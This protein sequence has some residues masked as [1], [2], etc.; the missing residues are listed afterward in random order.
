M[1]AGIK[2]LLH[3]I[4]VALL[5]WL[6]IFFSTDPTFMSLSK[7]R[8]CY[9]FFARS[10]G[11]GWVTLGEGENQKKIGTGRYKKGAFLL[12]KRK[13]AR[14]HPLRCCDLRDRQPL[15]RWRLWHTVPY[16][17]KKSRQQAARQ[18]KEWE[19][20]S[21]DHYHDHCSGRAHEQGQRFAEM[22]TP[23]RNILFCS[24][25]AHSYVNLLPDRLRAL[26]TVAKTLRERWKMDGGNHI[27]LS[28]TWQ[29]FGY[30]CM[31]YFLGSVKVL[32]KIPKQVFKKPLKITA[33][34]FLIRAKMK[35]QN[36]C[37]KI[38][39]R[40]EK[41]YLALLKHCPSTLT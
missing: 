1:D 28:A 15:L 19:S 14:S 34:V 36:L 41:Q 8:K 4:Y 38:N 35:P 37:K 21:K 31:I 40:G 39:S 5:C 13:N 29:M 20:N 26:F 9:F 23:K 6:L 7:P 33:R 16:G 2:R 11:G 24:P 18:F 12:R 3:P 17:V 22:N 30:L 27:Y 32:S 25:G 10:Q